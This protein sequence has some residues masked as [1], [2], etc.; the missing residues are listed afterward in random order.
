MQR[1]IDSTIQA[2]VRILLSRKWVDLA[3]LSIG[4]T[5]GVVYVGGTLRLL[6]GRGD[7]EDPA[8]PLTYASRLE[9]EI[10]ALPDVQ[11][12]VWRLTNG[13]KAVRS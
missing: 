8:W 12:V 11:D 13:E 9:Q 5:N 10:R 4:T 1:A 7:G 3:P 2:K 6:G